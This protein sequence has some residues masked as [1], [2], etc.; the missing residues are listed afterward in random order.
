MRVTELDLVINKVSAGIV[1][2]SS[3]I[4]KDAV[5]RWTHHI[6]KKFNNH[7]EDGIHAQ[8][9][10]SVL[11]NMIGSSLRILANIYGVEVPPDRATRLARQVA[12]E[13]VPGLQECA[14]ITHMS[15]K[16]DKH[17]LIGCVHCF[18]CDC[19]VHDVCVVTDET[20]FEAMYFNGN[21]IAEADLFFA[22]EVAT[23]AGYHAGRHPF[24]HCRRGGRQQVVG[25]TNRG[26]DR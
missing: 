20:E 13:M 9:A 6:A 12:G 3:R 10:T 25:L 18:P 1:G 21:L 16:C 22:S 24:R 19:T 8:L 17:D 5:E 2:V 23:K 15:D 7:A 4:A 11:V 26:A 14:S